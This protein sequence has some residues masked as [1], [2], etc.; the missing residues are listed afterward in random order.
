[1]AADMKLY[2][3]V[4]P[5]E[6]ADIHSYKGFRPIPSSL[7]GKWF[8][9]TPEHGAEWGR[10][11]FQPGPFHLLEAEIPQHLADQ[12]F[13]ISRLDRIGPARY[14]DDGLLQA[15]NQAKPSIGELPLTPAGYP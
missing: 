9:E 15:I 11:L 3:A 6:L 1:M 4:S 7:Q 12:M 13:T 2:R 8:A 5:Q 14:A 10:K